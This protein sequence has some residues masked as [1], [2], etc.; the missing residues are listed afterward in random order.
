MKKINK[1]LENI[2]KLTSEIITNTNIR[3]KHY[4]KHLSIA[5]LENESKGIRKVNKQEPNKIITSNKAQASNGHFQLYLAKCKN[6]VKRDNKG[7]III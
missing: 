5:S 3:H 1:R 2:S 4:H 6:Q 7:R